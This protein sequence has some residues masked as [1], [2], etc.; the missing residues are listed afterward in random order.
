MYSIQPQDTEV[1]L[2]LE[3]QGK[4]ESVFLTYSWVRFLEK[5]QGAEP[6]VLQ[7]QNQDK[8]AAAY[9]VGLTIKKA[10]IKILGSPFEGWLTCAMGFIRLDEINISDAL[11]CVAKYAFRELGCW[12]VQITDASIREEELDKTISFHK[13]KLLF[14]DNSRCIDDVLNGF[15]KNGRRDVRA[16]P[17]KG[18]QVVKVPF[19]SNFVERYYDQLIDVFAKQGMKPFYSLEKMYDLVEAFADHPE[20]VLALEACDPDGNKIASVFSF[21]YGKWAYFVGAAS[22]REFQKYLPNEGLF[23]EFVQHWNRVGI[24]NLDL[25]GYR[26]YK[27]KYAPEIR[28][29]PVIFFEKIPGLSLGKDL[30][31]KMV[32][33]ARKLGL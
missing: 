26:E 10:G 8:E 27:M 28:E 25:V 19:D 17:R 3:R 15:T 4:I 13:D 30:L 22:Y 23:F 31:K 1:L 5:N 33:F 29:V 32:S 21:G 2:E 12:Y 24:P 11:K 6:V 7:L 20:R 16:F 9:F 14:I 18:A